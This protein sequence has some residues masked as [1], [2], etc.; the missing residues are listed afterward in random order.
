MTPSQFSHLGP[1]SFLH[2]SQV[3][4]VQI[5]WQVNHKLYFVTSIKLFMNPI[6]FNKGLQF[7]IIWSSSLFFSFL[8]Q[9]FAP[10]YLSL[11]CTKTSQYN[12]HFWFMEDASIFHI[13]T[14]YKELSISISNHNLWHVNF[15]GSYYNSY[16]IMAS[17]LLKVAPWPSQ[18]PRHH[19]LVLKVSKHKFINI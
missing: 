5:T 6:F 12:F 2:S 10:E 13:R 15:Y 9:T 1:L 7:K 14:H 17:Y 19:L 3:C 18:M 16:S 11:E 8:M 4:L